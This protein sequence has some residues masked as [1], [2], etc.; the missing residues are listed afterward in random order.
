MKLENLKNEDIKLIQ[1]AILENSVNII[2]TCQEC[3]GVMPIEAYD[4]DME[5]ANRLIYLANILNDSSEYSRMKF[6]E[7]KDFG[8]YAL[9]GAITEEEAIEQYEEI[10]GEVNE[11]DGRP[12]E[13]TKEEAK[14]KRLNICKDERKKQLAIDEFTRRIHQD[15]PYLILVDGSLI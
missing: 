11:D 6:Y 12:I 3:K 2:A 7:F 4:K 8:Y 9:I 1:D 15:K 14:E 5:K 13:I 10:A